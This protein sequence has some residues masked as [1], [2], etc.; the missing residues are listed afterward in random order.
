MAVF[1]EW[2]WA[3]KWAWGSIRSLIQ[4]FNLCWNVKERWVSSNRLPNF[5][6]C[7][8]FEIILPLFPASMTEM[9][10][11]KYEGLEISPNH[12]GSIRSKSKQPIFMLLFSK[13]AAPHNFGFN[14][15]HPSPSG[16]YPSLKRKRKPNVSIWSFCYFLKIIQKLSIFRSCT[17]P[18]NNGG[19]ERLRTFSFFAKPSSNMR[20]TSKFVLRWG[21]LKKYFPL[22]GL[23]SRP[24][25]WWRALFWQTFFKRGPL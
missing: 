23:G 15:A 1:Y 14:P 6:F 22:N 20:I 8:N 11:C 5:Q 9:F 19:G 3:K 4:T 7:H 12:N 18:G 10:K 13:M 25:A 16:S 17:H 21:A 2:H 24:G